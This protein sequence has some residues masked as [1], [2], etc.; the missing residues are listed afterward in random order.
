MARVYVFAS[1]PLLLLCQGAERGK[2][3]LVQGDKC[4]PEVLLRLAWELELHVC[5]L[6]DE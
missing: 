5:D 4:L 3:L 1:S 2:N 6:L